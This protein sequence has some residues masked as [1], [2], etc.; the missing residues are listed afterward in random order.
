MPALPVNK[1]LLHAMH[2]AKLHHVELPA[3]QPARHAGSQ[4]TEQHHHAKQAGD[5]GSIMMT[6]QILKGHVRRKTLGIQIKITGTRGMA[7]GF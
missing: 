1:Y 6:A 2:R 7:V 5:Y 3:L 4:C